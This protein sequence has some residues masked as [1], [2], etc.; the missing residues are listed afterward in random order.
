DGPVSIEGWINAALLEGFQP[1]I[2]VEALVPA[3]EEAAVP[4]CFHH[5]RSQTAVPLGHHCF[6]E[7]DVAE[8]AVH[9]YLPA[10]DRSPQVSLFFL[11]HF[12]SVLG[13]ELEWSVGLGHKAGTADGDLNASL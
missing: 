3:V 9:L 5:D 8:M 4:V 1:G 7:T 6:Q 10:P 2:V 12:H 13:T 11:Q